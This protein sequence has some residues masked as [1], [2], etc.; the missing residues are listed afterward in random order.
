MQR[1]I[2]TAC[3]V[4]LLSLAMVITVNINTEASSNLP[5]VDGSYL[6]HDSES[7]GYACLTKGL[8][9][10]AGYSKV[11]RKGS[12]LLYAGGTTLARHTVESVQVSVM[13]ER[14][15]QEGDPWEFVDGW[16]TESIEATRA[17][18]FKL[19]YVEGGYYY[20]ARCTH[21]AGE[22]MSSSFTN[23]V[24]IEEP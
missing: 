21:S 23:G 7:I 14:V 18:T 19:L 16:H 9:Y 15:K 17:S 6:T 1:R 20:R 10:L 3:Y 22:D 11:I 8:D 24:Y 12:G 5:I 13:V 2:R 4:L